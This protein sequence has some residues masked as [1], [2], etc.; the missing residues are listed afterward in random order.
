[1]RYQINFWKKLFRSVEN[2]DGSTLD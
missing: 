1:M 2:E